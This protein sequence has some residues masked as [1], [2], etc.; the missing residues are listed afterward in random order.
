M[1]KL[2]INLAGIGRFQFLVNPLATTMGGHVRVGVEDNLY[3]DTD[4]QHL[5][6]NPALVERLVRLA[7]AAEREIATPAEARAMIGLPG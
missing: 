7:E 1:P 2:I 5:A 3:V 4:K 6:S